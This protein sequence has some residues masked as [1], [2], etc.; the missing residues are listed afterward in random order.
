[1]KCIA[2]TVIILY[3]LILIYTLGY[4]SYPPPY[5][6]HC[7]PTWPT[8]VLILIAVSW[9]GALIHQKTP[10]QYDYCSYSLAISFKKNIYIFSNNWCKDALPG[11]KIIISILLLILIGLFCLTY[12]MVTVKA[13]GLNNLLVCPLC[14]GYFQDPHIVNC[15][16]KTY[17]RDCLAK[18][19]CRG[20]VL[21]SY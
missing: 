5:S 2:T 18:V 15:C 20:E 17:C 21:L 16:H 9:F 10:L 19:G 7:I 1:M 8:R 13:R 3:I 12:S 14:S 11:E 4:N 6:I